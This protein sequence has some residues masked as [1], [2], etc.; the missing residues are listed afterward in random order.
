MAAEYFD[1]FQTGIAG[2][3]E[4]ARFYHDGFSLLAKKNRQARYRPGGCVSSPQQ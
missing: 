3:S 2:C 1:Q 4:N